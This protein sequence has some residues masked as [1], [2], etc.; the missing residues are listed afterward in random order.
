MK[1][2]QIS[3]LEN[4]PSYKDKWEIVA[5]FAREIMYLS[6]KLGVFSRV[7]IWPNFV[8][9]DTFLRSEIIVHITPRGVRRKWGGGNPPIFQI[10]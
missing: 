3:T 10:F 4:T 1:F 6:L 8:D 5:R 2:G 9:K 7:E